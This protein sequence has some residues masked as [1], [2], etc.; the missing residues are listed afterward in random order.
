MARALIGAWFTGSLVTLTGVV[1]GVHPEAIRY[2]STIAV[3]GF[4]FT[5]RR[6]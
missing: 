4:L 1:M 3:T 6:R 5:Y 2:A